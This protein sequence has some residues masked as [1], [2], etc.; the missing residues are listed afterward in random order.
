M[1]TLDVP[2]S[3]T[4]FYVL[5][6]RV[7]LVSNL[8]ANVPLP[9]HNLHLSRYDPKER[10]GSGVLYVCMYDAKRTTKQRHRDKFDDGEQ[11][12][13]ETGTVHL[14]LSFLSK[15][16]THPRTSHRIK[17]LTYLRIVVQQI[18]RRPPLLKLSDK[19]AKQ[20]REIQ[21]ITVK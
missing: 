18:C 16:P 10:T 3:T 20:K 4:C 6:M 21:Y 15:R 17:Q 8:H 2:Q 13:K 7:C 1:R 12:E 11:E 14:H 9:T 5:R 19:R